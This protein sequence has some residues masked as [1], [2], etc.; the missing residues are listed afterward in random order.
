MLKRVDEAAQVR[1]ILDLLE[2]HRSPRET[3]GLGLK[4]RIH[5][6]VLQARQGNENGTTR[7]IPIP[8]MQAVLRQ[9]LLYRLWQSERSPVL[10]VSKSVVVQEHLPSTDLLLQQP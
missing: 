6:L 7:P 4:A 9:L 10:S 2:F 3:V 8:S 5:L 1:S